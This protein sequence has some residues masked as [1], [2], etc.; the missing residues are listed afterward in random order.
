MQEASDALRQVGARILGTVLNFA[1]S[2]RRRGGYGY[3][4]G[5]YG[6]GAYGYGEAPGTNSSGR[7]VLG[8]DDV[9]AP[10]RPA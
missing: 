10:N 2:S 6:Y 7:T 4:K 8:S 9:Q 5:D 3:G 1:P